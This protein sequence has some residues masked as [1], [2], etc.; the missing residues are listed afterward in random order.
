M[1]LRQVWRVITWYV[2]YGFNH[3][4]WQHT[5]AIGLIALW[6]MTVT[7]V[8]YPLYIETRTLSAQLAGRSRRDA[9]MQQPDPRKDM[10]RD[11]VKDFIASLPEY[12][13]YP[14][15][16]RALVE[17]VDKGGITARRID[18][19]YERIPSLPIQ[20]LVLHLELGGDEMQQRKFMQTSL[21][22]FS[23]LSIARL[24][25]AKGAE[26]GSNAELKLDINLY[27]RLDK[28]PE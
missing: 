6:M 15:Q 23:N 19:Q 26:V 20:K 27:Y 24:S 21:N 13:R 17:L 9:T 8:D 2:K 3:L 28:A 4:E 7:I 10:S 14:E 22:T 5:L 16:L 11:L 1:T 18:Y 12:R 25:F